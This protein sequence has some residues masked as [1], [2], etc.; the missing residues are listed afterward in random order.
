MGLQSK[1]HRSNV[2]I[3]PNFAANGQPIAEVF[4][5]NGFSNGGRPPSLIFEIRDFIGIN[6]A[7]KSHHA[8][9]RGDRSNIC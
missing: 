4:R 1:V 3:M 6:M 2:V 8:K 9:F 7:N 5:F